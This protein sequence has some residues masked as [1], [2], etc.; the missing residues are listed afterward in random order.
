LEKQPVQ[1]N[2]DEKKKPFSVI[3]RSFIYFLS[4]K[5]ALKKFMDDPIH[6]LKQQSPLSV[7]PFKLC[8]I[9]PPKCGKST[10]ANRFVKEFGCVRLSVGEA[11]RAILINQP[12]TELAQE[13]QS[14]L[15]KGKT[16]PD[17]L[18]I[19][20]I[21]ISVLDVKCQ[22]KGYILDGFPM[23]KQQIKLMTDRSLIPVKVIE[24]KCD[25]KEIMQ[26]CIKDRTH[27]DRL[28]KN[29]ILNDSPEIIGY[30]MREWKVE[31]GFIRDW[32]SNEHKN[33]IQIDGNLSKWAI[34]NEA[35]QIGFQSVNL[36]QVY[37]NRVSMQKAASIANLCVTYGEMMSRLGDF[38]QYCPVSLGLNSELIDCSDN[39]TMDFVAEYQ[40]YYY[41]MKSAKELEIFLISPEKFV[42]PNASRKLPPPTELPK[43]R[44]AAESKS[45]FPK[46][47]ELNGYCPVT[48]FD[49]KERY[50]AIEQGFEDYAVEYKNKLYFMINSEALEKFMRKPEIYANLVLPHKLPPVKSPINLLNIPMTGYLEQHAADIMKRALVEVGTFKPKFPFLSPTRSGLLYVAYF[51]K[52]ISYNFFSD[53]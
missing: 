13:I 9:G 44:S 28:A 18:A 19:Q 33:F 7:V 3:H 27:P 23:T 38:G 37:L 15:I 43:K 46:G 8:I 2:Y 25:I 41:K 52:G 45:L 12:T 47:V 26:R 34:W 30:K 20:C 24:L 16:V 31:I 40:G 42:P 22:L 10:L 14:Y 53:N 50:E 5:I 11:I 17:E 32:Y 29:L 36:I 48:F 4:S 35:R 1:P 21:E 51:F 49:G 39:R 6:Y